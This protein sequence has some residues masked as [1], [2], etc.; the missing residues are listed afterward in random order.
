MGL[1]KIQDYLKEKG[2]VINE[3]LVSGNV[4][5]A[6]RKNSSNW[7]AMMNK[8]KDINFN[9]SEMPDSPNAEATGYRQDTD[10]HNDPKEYE[11]LQDFT[12]GRP[13]APELEAAVQ[14]QNSVSD[15]WFVVDEAKEWIWAGADWMNPQTEK[16]FEAGMLATEEQAN[17]V[18][19]VVHGI[20]L[21]G[22]QIFG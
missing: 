9:P 22:K 14:K 12:T 6:M 20:V 10:Y 3:S 7:K 11:K 17:R 1:K 13:S 18:A 4:I 5:E 19:S 15:G 16:D 8:G 21:S 2:L